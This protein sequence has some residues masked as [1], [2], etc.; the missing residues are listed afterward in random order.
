[1]RLPHD[2]Y[3]LA[4]VVTWIAADASVSINDRF[5]VGDFKSRRRE[6]E[7]TIFSFGIFHR[8]GTDDFVSLT[9]CL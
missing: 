2:D 3:D 9:R 8:Y 4:G 7:A 1:M 6:S 5:T